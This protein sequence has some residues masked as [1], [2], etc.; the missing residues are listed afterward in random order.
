MY[1]ID[2]KK[3]VFRTHHG[4]Y[5]FKVMSFRLINAHTTFQALIN[6]MLELFL[7]KFELVF[8]FND[9]LICNPTFELNAQDSIR[10]IKGS[11]LV[12]Q[13]I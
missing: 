2:I 3:I 8:F 4:Y 7:R 12:C 9:I 6:N 5:G 10:I 13:I 11:P 1:I